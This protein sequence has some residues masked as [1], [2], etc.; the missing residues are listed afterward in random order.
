[1]FGN[2]DKKGIDSE[3]MDHNAEIT[4]RKR[5]YDG[6]FKV[7]QLAIRQTG[8]SGEQNYTREVFERG[9]SVAVLLYDPDM[10]CV[11]LIEE[12]R[13]G[14]L[15]AGLS[16]ES[17]RALGPVAG[18]IEPDNDISLADA[19]VKTALR[20]V[21][22]ETGHIILENQLR[23]PLS[24]MVSPGGTSEVIHHFIAIVDIDGMTHGSVHGLKDEHEEIITHIISREEACELIGNGIQNGLAI[25]LLILLQRMIDNGFRAEEKLNSDKLMDQSIE[26]DM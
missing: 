7:E 18:T 15:A 9:N 17:C 8:P 23:G 1:M 21:E 11:V 12:L 22:E 19:A 26:M 2:T 5:V 6:F 10:D 25:T 3:N 24:T 14:P 20:E 13:P 16:L 4:A